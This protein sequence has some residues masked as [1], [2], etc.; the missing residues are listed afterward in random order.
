MKLAQILKVVSKVDGRRKI[1]KI[2]YNSRLFSMKSEGYEMVIH[3]HFKP[4]DVDKVISMIQAKLQKL[5]VTEFEPAGL[6]GITV[7]RENLLKTCET[8]FGQMHLSI[9]FTVSF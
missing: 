8:S 9:F 4:S 1:T 6:R 7:N 5:N 2:S 3:S